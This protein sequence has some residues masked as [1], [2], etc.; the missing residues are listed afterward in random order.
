MAAGTNES[1][2]N[3]YFDESGFTGAN[4]VDPEQPWFVY[5]GVAL[6]EEYAYAIRTEAY[7]RFRLQAPELKGAKLVKT[8]KGRKAISW[9]LETVCQYAR[10][11]VAD[12]RYALAGKFFDYMV[13]PIVSERNAVFY[14]IDF[15]KFVATHLAIG[16]QVDRNH[17]DLL[18]VF[19]KMMRK[20]DPAELENVFC[21]WKKLNESSP[22]GQLYNFSAHHRARIESEL[23]TARSTGPMAN[24][25]LEL[26]GTALYCLLCYWGETDGSLNVYCDNAK[27]L[28]AS[29]EFFDEFMGRSDKGYVQLSSAPP[30]SVIFNL[31]KPISLVDSRRSYGIQLADV[32][33]STLAFTLKRPD[34]PIS[35]E[36]R[37][38]CDTMIVNSIVPD[39]TL[40]DLKER[41]TFINTQVLFELAGD[42]SDRIGLLEKIPSIIQTAR[43]MY[44]YY[45]HSHEIESGG[46]VSK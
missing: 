4:L 24:W 22:I 45:L 35:K 1:T 12:K 34:E 23:I 17:Q 44:P 8:T 41:M 43:L 28:V 31:N 6:E 11:V 30:S 37:S 14:E 19:S 15:H 32:L 27:P 25:L 20:L 39:S 7:S 9:I 21:V 3:L 38:L 40:M 2:H 16:S 5:V 26:T 36:W 46:L 42:N 18:M 13:E 29:T 33:A 10:A